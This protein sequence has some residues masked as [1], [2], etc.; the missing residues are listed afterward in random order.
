M[1]EGDEIP[2]RDDHQEFRR[3]PGFPGHSRDGSWLLGF[4]A[5]F[6][7]G[8]V[9]GGVTAG[10]ADTQKS[11]GVPL[12]IDDPKPYDSRMGCVGGWELV[13]ARGHYMCAWRLEETVWLK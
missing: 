7:L 12:Q 8:F 4:A 10:A 1:S 13:I 5:G 3:Y 6:V 9:I 2:L 11:S